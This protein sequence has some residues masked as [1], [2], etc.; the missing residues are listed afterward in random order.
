MGLKWLCTLCPPL[1][2][3][4]YTKLNNM[5]A[6]TQMLKTFKERYTGNIMRVCQNTGFIHRTPAVPAHM[7][8]LMC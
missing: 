5:Q 2:L 4:V 1:L 6:C 8:R 3:Q 7:A